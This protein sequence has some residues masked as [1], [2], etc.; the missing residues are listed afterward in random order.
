MP[1][2]KDATT[3]RRPGPRRHNNWLI[4][5]VLRRERRGVPAAR[6]A[7][8]RHAT[9]EQMMSRT[10]VRTALRRSR[11]Q[12]RHVSAVRPGAA[13]DPVRT[14]YAQIERDFG[15]LAPPVIL[16]SPAPGPLAAC[17][18]M[19]R[20]TLVASGIADRATKEAVA[21]AVSA[22]NTC[23]YCVEVHT[24][25]L[26]GLAAG[27]DAV[28]T[29]RRVESGTDSGLREIATWA[30]ESGLRHPAA[31]RDLPFPP[32]LVPELA[33]VAI[34][35][36]YLNR[37]VNVFLGDSP[38]PPAVPGP[39]R[40]GAKQLLGR[41]M[42]GA[43]RSRTEPGASLDL[44]PAAPLPADLA[45]AAGNP[46]I[47][48]AFARAAAAIDAAGERSVPA[49]VR[50]L[51]LATLAQWDGQPAGRSR[52]WVDTAVSGLAVAH[53]AAGRLALLTAVASY[54]VG[55][56]DVDAIRDGGRCSDQALVELTSWSSMAAARRIATWTGSGH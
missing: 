1:R 11:T 5:D 46:S 2:P 19:L 14:I 53:R 39:A 17:W 24:A 35:F 4:T 40:S 37:M 23:P 42:A 20:E 55:Q 48:G 52:G 8:K 32:E 27:R 36:Q 12:I 38:L 15:M 22:S 54:Q 26:H 21:A 51:V 7:G 6:R 16:H 13:R 43:A 34:T 29:R 47:A 3:M 18:L 41:F 28:A 49:P 31:G 50:D 30:R 33:G 44:L 25:T 56:S 10:L 9:E 45:W